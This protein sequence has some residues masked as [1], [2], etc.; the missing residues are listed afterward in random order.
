[1]KKYLNHEAFIFFGV[2]I[3]IGTL[4]KLFGTLQIDSDWFWCLTGIALT[5]EGTIALLKQKQFD[6]KDQFILKDSIK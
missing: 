6:R 5:I 4:L 1:M 2:L 3:V